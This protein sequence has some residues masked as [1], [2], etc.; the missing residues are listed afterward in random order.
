MS[1]VAAGVRRLSSL[2]LYLAKGWPMALAGWS[3]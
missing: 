1:D 2:A 3:S